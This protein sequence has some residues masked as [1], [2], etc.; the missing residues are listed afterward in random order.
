[1]PGIWVDVL[2]TNVLLLWAG[3]LE[4]AAQPHLVHLS[5]A[6][7]V[8]PLLCP[9]CH[10]VIAEALLAGFLTCDVWKPEERVHDARP[11]RCEI[12]VAD[13]VSP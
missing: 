1:M 4:K 7:S 13:R 12:A 9:C 6:A 11:F 5:P 8:E 3:L 2:V 10:Q